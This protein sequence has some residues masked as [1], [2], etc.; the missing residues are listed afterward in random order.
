MLGGIG[1]TDAEERLY[2]ALI[3]LG[4]ATVDELAVTDRTMLVALEQK[5]LASRASGHEERFVPAP[6]DVAIEAL[7]ARRHEE[8]ARARL[9][10]RELMDAFRAGPRPARAAEVLEVVT[11]CAAVRN[12]FQQLQRSAAWELLVFDKP[13]Y[14]TPPNTNEETE[15][16]L[17]ARGVRYRVVYDRSSLAEP[18]QPARLEALV[19]AGQQARL[20]TDLPMKLVIADRR[21]ALTPL[22]R[23]H[24]LTDAALLVHE[25]ALLDVLVALFD[26]VWLRAIP[27][28]DGPADDEDGQLLL[29]LASGLKDAAI[30]RQLGLGERT[31]RRR[32]AALADR[33]GARTRFQLGVQ[34]A[35]QGRL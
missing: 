31:V 9:A 19:A 23:H 29:M 14:T 11:G 5:G 27:V 35:R 25:S 10:V 13:P 26:S 20:C 24:G 6:P 3:R 18:G 2:R 15:R 22:S 21:L 16:N 12:R 34:A 30:A 28:P 4:S 7:A 32:V 17:L 33:L 1:V 8:L